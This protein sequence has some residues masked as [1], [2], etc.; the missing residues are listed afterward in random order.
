MR[1]ALVRHPTV[2]TLAVTGIL[3]CMAIGA[4]GRLAFEVARGK[5]PD[6][7]THEISSLQCVSGV[8]LVT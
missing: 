1:S 4:R 5:C 6:A 8:L 3:C 7:T 2:S